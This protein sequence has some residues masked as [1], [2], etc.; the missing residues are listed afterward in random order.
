MKRIILT[1]AACILALGM[2]AQTA[3]RGKWSGTARPRQVTRAVENPT[4]RPPMPQVSDRVLPLGFAHGGKG[5]L[6]NADTAQSRAVAKAP[7]RVLGDGTTIYGSLIFSGTWQGS[8]GSYGIYSFP[9]SE[10]EVPE[11]VYS[12]GSYEANGG[13]CYVDG[14]YYWNSYVY[15]PEMGYT[16]ST[17]CSYDF[18][19]K[20]F[21]K[22]T[23]SFMTQEF[24]QSQI[25]IGMTYDPTTS[26]I[27]ALSYIAQ[28]LADGAMQRYYPAISMVDT[29]SGFV[30]PIARVPAMVAIAVNQ[31]GELYGIT[32]GDNSTL[33]RIN[34]ATGDIT[35]IGATGLDTDFVQ[36]MAFDPITDKLYWAAVEK[37]GRTG[38]YE[39]STTAG[40]ASKICDFAASE[41]YTGLYIPAPQVAV[42]APAC[43]EDFKAEFTADS[44]SGT[45]SL[46]LPAKTHEGTALSGNLTLSVSVDGTEA[47]TG[48]YAPGA[49]V[50]FPVTLDEGTH[51]F[52]ATVSNAAGAGPRVGISRYVG[53]DGPEAVKN[54]KVKVVNGK[55]AVISWDAPEKGRHDGYIDPAKVRY[56]VKRFPGGDFVAR[57]ISATSVD[58]PADVASNNYIYEVT[59]YCDGR[60]GI[61]AS[62]AP[63]LIGQGTTLPCKFD[64]ATREA[65]D[66]FTVIDANHDFDA[67]YKWGSW[68]YGPEF[69]YTEEDGNCAVYGYSPENAADDWLITPP[70]RVESGKHYRLTYTM[71]TRG[72]SETLAVTAGPANT[73]EAQTVITPAKDY[74]HKDHKVFTAD[75]TA[76]ATG[77]YYAGFHITSP[78]KHFYLMVTDIMVDEIPDDNAPAAVSALK[79]EAAPKGEIKATVSFTV[80]DKT[81]AG[82]A[83]AS[84]DRVDIYR[85]NDT[86]AAGTFSAP[87]PGS[88]QSWTD[89]EPD[90]GFNTYRVVAYSAGAA[91]AKA[92]ARVFV[93]YDIP[94][95]PTA[96]KAEEKDGKV[97]LSWTAPTEGQNGGY[98]NPDELVYT[99]YR[100]GDEAAVIAPAAK[101]LAFEDTGLDGDA[102][103]Y[104]VYYTIVPVSKA[105]SG[106]YAVSDALIFGKPYTGNFTESFSDGATQNNPWVMYRVKGQTQLWGLYSQGQSPAC[107][108]VD[109][110]Y[111]V[112]TF[113][114]TSGRI[115]DEGRLVSPKLNL[116]KMTLPMLSFYIY[117]KVSMDTQY[118]E[119]PFADR[120][121]PEL[122]LPDGSYVPLDEAIYVDDPTKTDGWYKYEY[123]L[124]KY[125]D[126]EYV[127]LSFHGI[128]DYEQDVNMDLV[129]VT[130]RISNDLAVY[131]FSGPAS[132]RAGE[133]GSFKVTIYNRGV[134]TAS[135]Y[136]VILFRDGI[137]VGEETGTPLASGKYLTLEFED[138]YPADSEGKTYKYFAMI[139][140]Q[141]DEFKANDN[142]EAISVKVIEPVLPEVYALDAAKQGT[143]VT[144]NWSAP[145]ALRVEDSFES[146]PA[147]SI[148]NIGDYTLV[149]GDKGYTYGFSDIYFEN[150]GAPQ[151]FMVFNPVKLGIVMHEANASLFDPRT[152]DQVLACFQAAS[153]AGGSMTNDDWLISPEVHGGQKISF[154]AKAGNYEWG[155]DRF[156]VLYSTSDR[157]TSVFKPFDG[158]QRA[159]KDWK[160]YEYT[161]PANARYFAIHCV[162]QDEF[163]LFIDDLKFISRRNDCVLTHTGYRIYRDGELVKELPADATSYTDKGL[164]GEDYRYDITAVYDSTR[165]SARCTAYIGQS[166][167]ENIAG[168]SVT[169][170]SE[171][172]HILIGC[173][174][175]AELRVIG[176]DGKTLYSGS[177]SDSHRVATG[178]GIFIVTVDGHPYKIAVR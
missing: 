67:E 166:S 38:L 123:D 45:V 11:L 133:K 144:L 93:G 17:F 13:G 31:S 41:E 136:K 91:G 51:A 98:I 141:P 34:K 125:R 7:S 14:K 138:S 15:T 40:T 94:V 175:E 119:E 56:D 27:Y 96:F 95:A 5:Q 72:Q 24:D 89:I 85:G 161:L 108:P 111:G 178:S 36:S 104:F 63:T 64:F 4:P 150:T 86:E 149:D 168:S 62:T 10:Y 8:T 134:E 140:W 73:V 99:I 35:E 151:A 90:A 157:S 129:Q 66:L 22:K 165:E 65:Y 135:D 177:G 60:L 131:T 105:G 82:A 48:S 148:D 114:A 167:V 154:Y 39:V 49:T 92:E 109:N 159:G 1:G 106:D 29:Y 174:A 112:A 77:N 176:A 16:F 120:M 158:V 6:R 101:G 152:G 169:V 55:S 26:S 88:A 61:A 143:D 2:V 130:N 171:R 107:A 124:S 54:L 58:D 97:A 81:V 18:A 9:A 126:K 76:S 46:R 146:Y 139:S 37:T 53:L 79:A 43:V 83:L 100:G 103:Q 21:D 78:K 127:K 102:M 156:E 142:S 128:A 170:S 132:V 80:P 52:T 70:F 69:K 122:Q 25:T 110:D 160:K 47:H 23:Q 116:S 74:N 87:A 117:H 75:F 71:W 3:E 12:Q 163:I 33:C 137:Q 68:M 118:G 153:P 162:S 30:T 145:S 121:I 155:N 42:G 19:T 113:S 59:P 32:K 115:G 44:H 147:Y 50:S 173:P 164:E 84:V 20:Q 57:G 28:E 172:G